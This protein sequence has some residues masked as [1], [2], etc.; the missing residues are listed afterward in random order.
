MR[1]CESCGGAVSPDY[2]RVF[3][4]NSGRIWACPECRSQTDVFEGAGADPDEEGR[5]EIELGR[6]RGHVSVIETVKIIVFI[7]MTLSIPL[8]LLVMA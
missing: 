3:G 5:V 6:S 2:A 7:A 1:E 8:L 4:D